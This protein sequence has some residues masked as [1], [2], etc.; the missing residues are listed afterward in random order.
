MAQ[1]PQVGQDLLIIKTSR[2]H[3]IRHEHS[4]GLL[5]RSDQPEAQTFTWK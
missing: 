1:N 2:S 5:S 4:V 3:T